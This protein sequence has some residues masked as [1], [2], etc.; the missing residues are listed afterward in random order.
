VK[1]DHPLYFI[2]YVS[3]A[4]TWF[5]PTE[6]RALLAS[7]RASNERAGITG[8]LLYKDGNF[9]QALEGDEGA[10]RALQTRIELDRRHHGMVTIC[11]DHAE[12]RQFA[13][14]S[15][16]F[17]DLDAPD[18][19]LPAGYSR[20]FDLPLTDPT[21]TQAPNRCQELLNLFRRID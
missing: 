12:A 16:A 7:S 4:V 2:V 15:M 8:M 21:F 18:E 11:A 17:V 3:A 19:D 20:F 13:Q 14:W 9:M 10:V 6:L 5:S 1:K